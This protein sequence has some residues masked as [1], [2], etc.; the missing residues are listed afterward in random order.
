ML[1]ACIGFDI[2][3]RENNI[4][5]LVLSKMSSLGKIIESLKHFLIRLSNR[6]KSFKSL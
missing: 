4:L 6:L 1:I 2:E 5:I 3:R